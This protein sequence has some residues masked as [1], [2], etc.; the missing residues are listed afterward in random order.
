MQN[1]SSIGLARGDELEFVLRA[2][3]SVF[4]FSWGV[5]LK[6]AAKGM[7]RH[8]AA[9]GLGKRKKCSSSA[10]V[11][12]C[13]CRNVFPHVAMWKLTLVGKYLP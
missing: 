6:I 11:A 2:L 3:I 1:R 12:A 8:P 4:F 9:V 5:G 13:A 7:Q 10:D